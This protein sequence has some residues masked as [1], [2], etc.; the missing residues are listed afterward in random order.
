MLAGRS[1]MVVIKPSVVQILV[2]L[3]VSL[4]E[5]TQGTYGATETEPMSRAFASPLNIDPKVDCAVKEL[6]WEYAKKLLPRV[7][8][9]WLRILSR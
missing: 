2:L 6:A 3:F 1:R 7:S 5:T 8:F 9:T 4:A